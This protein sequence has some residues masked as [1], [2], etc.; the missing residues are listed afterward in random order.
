MQLDQAA[1]SPR[2]ASGKASATTSEIRSRPPGRRTRWI[3][4]KTAGLS[5]ERLITQLLTTQSDLHVGESGRGCIRFGAPEHLGGHVHADDAP[6]G[7][8]ALRREQAV[9]AG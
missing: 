4:L 8:D 9:N 7:P 2:T 3:S 6:G 5:G 1:R